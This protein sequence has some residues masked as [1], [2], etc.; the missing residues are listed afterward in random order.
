MTCTEVSVNALGIGRFYTA[1]GHGI[2]LQ[3]RPL[4]IAE[5]MRTQVVGRVTGPPNCGEFRRSAE[6]ARRQ[7]TH[8]NFGVATIAR[9]SPAAPGPL[10]SQLHPGV[11][12]ELP[13]ERQADK[14]GGWRWRY[15]ALPRESSGG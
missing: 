2:G 3:E 12:D 6:L 5:L 14:D 7:D 15:D 13:V 1:H 11:V 4:S 8:R 9:W 10:Q